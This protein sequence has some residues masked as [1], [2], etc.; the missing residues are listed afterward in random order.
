MWDGA[1]D[2]VVNVIVEEGNVDKELPDSGCHP[3]IER[4]PIDPVTNMWKDT[5][6]SLHCYPAAL[7]VI[8]EMMW[9]R[10]YLL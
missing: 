10:S 5:H 4:C 6:V 9:N 8:L 7:P 3:L 1:S 2:A